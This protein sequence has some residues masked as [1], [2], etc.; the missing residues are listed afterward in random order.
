MKKINLLILFFIFFTSI[1]CDNSIDPQYTI[2]N[3]LVNID[4]PD[5]Q[6]KVELSNNNEYPKIYQVDDSI[7]TVIVDSQWQSFGR[8]NAKFRKLYPGAKCSW[9]AVSNT[10][11]TYTYMGRVFNAPL[12]N[13][14]S[15]FS[16]NSASTVICFYSE[17]IGDTMLA[18]GAVSSESGTTKYIDIIY[19]VIKSK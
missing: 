12:I 5:F 8:I 17:C 14:I 2:Y 11:P 13:N 6:I 1:G 3:P 9:K 19:F 18:S 16:D 15:Y 4:H 10:N 7:Y